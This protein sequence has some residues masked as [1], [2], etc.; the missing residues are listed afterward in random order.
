M[1][2][3]AVDE[4]QRPPHERSGNL[5][6]EFDGGRDLVATR[7]RAAHNRSMFELLLQGHRRIACHS[8]DEARLQ[9]RKALFAGKDVTFHPE[10]RDEETA[11]RSTRNLLSRLRDGGTPTR[12]SW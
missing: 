7:K 10:W 5:L 11:V 6:P 12:R 3:E 4:V 8:E 2:Q 1:L 9:E